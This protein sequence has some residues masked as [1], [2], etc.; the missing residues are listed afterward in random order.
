MQNVYGIFKESKKSKI[1]FS[2]N[3][4][5]K[6]TR[7]R[8]IRKCLKQRQEEIRDNSKIIEN[9]TKQQQQSKTNRN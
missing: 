1:L 3:I 6:T 4:I 2:Y 7:K 5:K 8:Q 9:N